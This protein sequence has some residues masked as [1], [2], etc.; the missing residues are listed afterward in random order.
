MTDSQRYLALYLAPLPPGSRARR[1]LAEVPALD[2]ERCY[3]SAGEQ[4]A[5][6]LSLPQLFTAGVECG[7]AEARAELKRRIA[8]YEA[9][10]EGYRALRDRAQD[11]RKELAAQ[12]AAAQREQL[13]RQ[14]HL[15]SLE[16]FLS[17]ARARI[18]QL[19]TS[20]TWRATAPLRNGAHRAKVGL[21][22]LRSIWASMRQSPRYTGVALSLLRNEGAGAL[23]RRV[24]RRIRRAKGFTPA[25][26]DRFVQETE[27]LPLAFAACAE[28]RVTIVIPAYGKPLLTYTCLKSVRATAPAGC[29]EVLVIDD[30][31]PQQLSEQLAPVSGVRFVRN[32]TNLGFV[33]TCNRA[34]EHARGDILVFLNNDTIATAGWLE[35]LL[36]VFERRPDAGLVGA[37][38]VYPDGRLQE[39]GGIVWRD[40]SAWNYGRDDD[41]GRPEYNYLREVD[42]CSGACLAVPRALFAQLGGFD[43]RFAPA[44]YEDVDLAFAVRASGRKVY[45]QPL[46]SVVHFEG[47]TAGTDETAGVKRH[48]VLNRNTFVTKW[49]SALGSHRPNGVAPEFERDRWA[50][51]RLLIIDA[52]MLTP[53]QDAG[54]MR[55]EQMLE[56]LVSLGCKVTFAADN[57]EYR[58]PYVSALQQLGVEVQF[59]P[60][61]RSIAQL[62]GARGTEFDI[63]MLSRHYIAIKHID[64]LRAFA[65]R[66][67]IVFDTVDLHFLRE[68]RLAELNASRSARIAAV[69]KR[70]E[71][72]VLI[73]KADLTLVVSP[74]EQEL[75][76]QLAP[77]ARV[78][79]LSTI[80]EPLAGGKPFAEREGLVFI[81]GFRH[82]PNTD[83]VLWYAAEIL[84]RLRERLPGV[85]TYIIGSDPP[86]PIKALAGDDLVIAG[87]VPDVTPY[88]TGCRASVSPLRYG[89]GV[90]GKLNLAMSY[91]L[92]VVATTPSIEGMHLTPEVDVLVAD[93]PDAFADAVARAY[94]DETL[95]A[96]LSEGGRENIRAHFSREVARGAITRLLAMSPDAT[97]GH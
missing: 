11:D 91:G 43:A 8:A 57:L 69:A 16:K 1:Q 35:A 59:A 51:R 15:A 62:L 27:I 31:S 75:L 79:V 89:A 46:A 5:P 44:Y 19:E 21:A 61:A 3:L 63:V 76:N 18:D 30:A 36:S 49:G 37:K 28:P 33:A 26:G 85:I 71:E 32:K 45:Y 88:F 58:Q 4:D 34:L 93:S 40:G 9:A 52:C 81:G 25:P 80:H 39:A 68:E 13:T 74:V 82:P 29:Y 56:L 48:Q 65:P 22:S 50:K 96:R 77:E 24:V 64:T 17:E 23:A 73:H 12:L 54:S 78:M 67:L 60:Y 10:L 20:T 7:H 95:W 92:P 47:A 90:K 66:A 97:L 38:L 55:M 86:P 2:P 87:Y 42:Y 6:Q 83:A 41:P 72:L 14:L 84:P 53:D 94:N 70:N